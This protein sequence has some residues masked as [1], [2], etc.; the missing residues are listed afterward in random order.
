M[1]LGLEILGFRRKCRGL[2]GA[3]AAA[4]RGAGLKRP[5]TCGR[6]GHVLE[7]NVRITLRGRAAE[8]NKCLWDDAGISDE[9]GENMACS[10]IT[11]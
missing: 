2:G 11:L 6:L 9:G 10:E 5:Q 8:E 7:H 4:L 1:N 3:F